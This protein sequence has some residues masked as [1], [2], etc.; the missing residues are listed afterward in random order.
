MSLQFIAKA[1]LLSIVCMCTVAQ[2]QWQW[3]DKD[4]KRVFSDRAPT[5]DVPEKN[6][7]KRP[8]RAANAVPATAPSVGSD[9]SGVAAAATTAAAPAGNVIKLPSADKE[10][11][12]R[13]KAAADLEAAKRKADEERVAKARAD[14]CNRAKRDKTTVD[15]G[16]R[17]ARTNDKGEREV[18]DDAMR[19]AES[20]R[21]K[22][23]MDADCR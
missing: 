5:A 2:A 18:F 1:V 4:G 21:L 17:M 11:E 16:V 23:I 8:G 19:A 15:S 10:L 6:I 7:L 13:K 14:N 3:L 20:K 12:A 22:E 9:T